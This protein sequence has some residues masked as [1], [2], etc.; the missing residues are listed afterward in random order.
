[1][2]RFEKALV[3]L[4]RAACCC[5]WWDGF[6]TQMSPVGEREGGWLMADKTG[7]PRLLVLVLVLG[8]VLGAVGAQHLLLSRDLV[9]KWWDETAP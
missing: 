6:N 5:G 7:C 1:M 3:V 2:N 4:L 8:L 9:R